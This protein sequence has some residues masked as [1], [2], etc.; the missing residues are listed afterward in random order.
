LR[1]ALERSLL[2][3]HYQPIIDLA[4][5]RLRAF[6]ALA[7]WP[8]GWT[9][10]A[11]MEFIPIAEE[12]GLI[13]L[14]GSHVMRRSLQALSVWR[15]RGLVAEDVC[16]SVN[17]SG[18]QLEDPT[19]PN[20]VQ[21]ALASAGLSPEALRLEITESTL[22]REHKVIAETIAEVCD[23]GVG[24]HL[25]DFG[26]GYSSLA[27]LHRCPVGALKIDRSFVASLKDDAPENDVIIRST[28]ALAHSFGLYVVAEGIE[29]VVQLRCLRTL[30]CEYGQGFLFSRPVSEEAIP[31][32][33]LNWS[34]SAVALLGDRLEIE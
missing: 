26:T 21:A 16:M 3:V 24:L 17:V 30:G 5:G 11:P 25:D 14:L 18:L 7:R 4:T 20:Q 9:S 19:L 22:M 33:L 10:V 15:R 12:T 13:G 23:S 31:A 34:P 32:L 1:E 28:V 27:M 29:D 6:E 8:S 2:E